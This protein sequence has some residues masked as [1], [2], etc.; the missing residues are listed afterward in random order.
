[1]IETSDSSDL[2]YLQN[3][4]ET[5]LSASKPSQNNTIFQKQLNL[6]SAL[7]DVA[8]KF[9]EVKTA[10]SSESNTGTVRPRSPTGDMAGGSA[11]VSVPGLGLDGTHMN[12]P[13]GQPD[14]YGSMGDHPLDPLMWQNQT[15]AEFGME[16]NASAAELAPWFYTNQ[17]MMRMLD[18]M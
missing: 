14:V 9:F 16:T 15:L 11:A 3:L 1:M 5:L 17:H 7:Y 13:L 2:Y 12:Q 10:Y 4:I 8:V 18:D 6:F